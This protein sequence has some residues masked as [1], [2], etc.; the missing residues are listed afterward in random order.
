METVICT[1]M[2]DSCKVGNYRPLCIQSAMTKVLT[3][4]VMPVL[5][6]CFTNIITEYEHEFVSGRSTMTWL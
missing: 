1:K 4:M 2:G 3:K 6:H 5:D